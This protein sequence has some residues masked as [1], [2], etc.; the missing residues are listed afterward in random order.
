MYKTICNYI[1][2]TALKHIAVKSYKYQN[3]TL[4]NAQG[5]N[6]YI[7][8]IIENTPYFQFIKTANVYT[9]TINI[10]ILGFPKGE[11]DV[12]DVQN[13]CFQVGNE[14]LA[15]IKGD[16]KYKGILSIYDWDFLFVTH[17]SDDSASG[18]RLTLELVVPNPID[19]CTFMDN[20]DEDQMQVEESDDIDLDIP[21]YS[22]E[23]SELNLSP[24]KLQK[25]K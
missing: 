11:A 13:M 9:L 7:Q 19:L 10:D 25:N 22:E 18:V 24:I 20:F 15:Y 1:G 8:F 12:L 2:E 21:S 16:Y 23:E 4:I 17:F 6:R 14:V 5:N 3:K